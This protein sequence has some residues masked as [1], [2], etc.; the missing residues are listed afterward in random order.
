MK[1]DKDEKLKA[2]LKKAG[3]DKPA[4]GFTDSIM[5]IIEADAAR[6]AALRSVL[7]QHPAEG[8][9][10]DFTA[11]VM[12]GLNTQRKPLVIQP[13][14]SKRAW[15]AISAVFALLLA[16]AFWA[17]K[18]SPQTMA[19]NDQITHWVKQIQAIPPTLVLYI[20]LGA[21]LLIADYWLSGRSKAAAH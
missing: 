5:Q 8:P 10:F 6:E 2:L 21:I 12:R 20:V 17:G 11:N 1:T 15:Y 7:K 18:S 14:I 3:S 13:V 16:V 9:S 4:E 19:D